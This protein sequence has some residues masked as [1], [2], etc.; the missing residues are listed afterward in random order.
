MSIVK[1]EKN[2]TMT[3]YEILQQAYQDA[4]QRLKACASD[5]SAEGNRTFI[6]LDR[7]CHLAFNELWYADQRT[8]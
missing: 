2:Q 7:E 5:L 3:K 1:L 4:L 6:A 8:P